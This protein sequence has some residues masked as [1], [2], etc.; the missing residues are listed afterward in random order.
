MAPKVKLR[1]PG[2]AELIIRT[3][4]DKV[5]GNHVLER[6]ELRR[7]FGSTDQFDAR[8]HGFEITNS[9]V[10]LEPSTFIG[11]VGVH[12]VSE[13]ADQLLDVAFRP[14]RGNEGGRRDRVRRSQLVSTLTGN[15]LI[16]LMKLLRTRL[17]SPFNSIEASRGSSSVN[18]SRISIRASALPRQ[19]CGLP[20]P[21]VM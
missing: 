13:V 1:R 4:A 18:M 11:V 21:K 20:L 5:A 19:T 14:R 17:T 6:L 8:R 12:L 7:I 3:E 10:E 15:F 9:K 2:D 16:P